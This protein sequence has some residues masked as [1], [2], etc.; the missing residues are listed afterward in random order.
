MLLKIYKTNQ[1]LVLVTLPFVVLLLWYPSFST[2]SQLIIENPTLIFNLFVSRSPITNNITALILIISSALILNNTINKNAFF[3]RNVYLS[4]FLYLLLTSAVP[5]LNTL[6]PILFSNLFIILAFR[7][8]I[9]I[10]SQVSCKSEVFDATLLFLLAGAFYPPSLLLIPFS[11]FALFIFRPFKLK[12]WLTPF[13][14]LGIFLIY[15]FS[16]FLFLDNIKLF[17]PID[18][19]NYSI[20]VENAHSYFFYGI[21]FLSGITFIL[22]LLQIHKKRQRSTIQFKKMTNSMAVFFIWGLFIFTIT[23]NHTKT[24]EFLYLLS[25]PFIISMTYFFLYLKKTIVAEII[26]LALTVLILINNYF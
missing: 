2:P 15:Y 20:Y 17:S 23:S 12:E 21:G 8:L 14:A 24:F 22:G 19:L 16:S 11:W 1:P 4:S 18:I 6:H 9:S 3:N 26:L 13:I 25:I 5:K 10:H 7:R